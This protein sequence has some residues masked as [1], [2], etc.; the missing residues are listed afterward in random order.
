MSDKK[1]TDVDVFEAII[2]MMMGYLGPLAVQEFRQIVLPN[3]KMSW[4]PP[5]KELS[6]AEF[7]AA[8]AKIK[9]ELPYFIAWLMH[10][11]RNLPDLPPEW[12]SAS[13]N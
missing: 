12:F 5:Q 10:P 11:D 4:R 7:D 1:K 13:R 9:E 3:L 6:D 2:S 8:V